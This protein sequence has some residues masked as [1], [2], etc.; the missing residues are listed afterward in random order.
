MDNCRVTIVVNV[1]LA[2]GEENKIPKGA[3]EVFI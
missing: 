3:I 1:A 2:P